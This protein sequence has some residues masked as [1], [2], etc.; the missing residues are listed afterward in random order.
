MKRLESN[1]GFLTPGIIDV[2]KAE[3]ADEEIFGPLLQVI[4]ASTLDEALV[5]ANKTNYGLT[6]GIISDS[7]AEFMVARE[8]LEAGIVNW[9]LPLTGISSLA[10]FGGIKDS[11]NC[12]PAGYMAVD[13]CNYPQAQTTNPKPWKPSDLPPGFPKWR[14][15]EA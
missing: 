1:T 14:H 8:E 10:P 11:G 12:R 4:F 3:V 5:I 13:F 7:E 9:N 2:T 15:N 6:A